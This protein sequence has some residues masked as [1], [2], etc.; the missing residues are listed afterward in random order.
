ML[1]N[2]FLALLRLVLANYEIA[3]K[4]DKMNGP[5]RVNKHP[6]SVSGPFNVI[7]WLRDLMANVVVLCSV[8]PFI[9]GNGT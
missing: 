1:L 8:Y 7:N 3:N 5:V 9:Q 6:L 2:F 4:L